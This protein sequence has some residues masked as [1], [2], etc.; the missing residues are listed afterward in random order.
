MRVG[1]AGVMAAALAALA[2]PAAPQQLVPAQSEVTFTSRQ[3]GVP[4][5]GRF[6]RFDAKMVFDPR[7]PEGGHV[8]ITIDVGSARFGA[9]ETDAEVPKPV[10]F[11]LAK[12][13]QATFESSSIKAVGAGRYDVAGRLTLKGRARDVVVPVTLAFGTP[14]AMASG[15]FT[16]RRLDFAIGDGEWAD[17][18]LV[19]NDVQVHFKLALA[20]LPPS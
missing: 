17:T 13:P 3:M 9:P 15:S 8:T 14:Y 2:A 18:S 10:W 12:F 11:H 5:E 7:Q 20:G 6:G 4:V 19:A 1:R 16:L